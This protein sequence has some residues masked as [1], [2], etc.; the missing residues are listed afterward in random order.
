MVAIIHLKTYIFNRKT[1]GKI[2]FELDYCFFQKSWVVSSKDFNLNTTYER[3]YL[4]E[5]VV[6]PGDFSFLFGYMN[7]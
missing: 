6:V 3:A 4:H 1:H 2:E 5:W 7:R